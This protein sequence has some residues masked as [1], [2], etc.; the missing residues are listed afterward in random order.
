MHTQTHLEKK[1]VIGFPHLPAAG[2][3]GSFQIRLTKALQHEGVKIVFPNDP[4]TPDL[5]LVVGGTAKLK[6]LWDCKR[7]GSKIVH[8]LDGIN[9]QHRVRRTT[10]QH[11]FFS[12]VRNYLMI[13]IRKYFADHVVYQSKFIQD[14]WHQKYGKSSCEESIIYNGVDLSLYHPEDKTISSTTPP[15]LLCVEGN[16]QDDPTTLSILK[17]LPKRLSQD[18]S[19]QATLVC[20]GVS[21]EVQT[22]LAGVP[23]L[24][25]PGKIPREQMQKIFA[26]DAIFLTL[27]INHACPNSVIEALAAGLPVVGYD[28]GSLR[29]LV[30]SEAGMIVPPGSDPWQMELPNIDALEEAIRE[31]LPKRSQYGTAARR[32]AEARFGL[33][34]VSESYLAIFGKTLLA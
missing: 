5:I 10:L 16:L 27:D 25:L 30:S 31:V 15:L 22:Q 6:W 34:K 24:K 20:G 19:I 26:Q 23:G 9:W 1:W 18:K 13:L 17:E 14:W 2:G 28:T 29:E 12:E 11:F 4:Q 33:E 32:L 8:R 21:K 7:K 3:P